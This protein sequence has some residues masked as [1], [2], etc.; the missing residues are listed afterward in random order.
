MELKANVLVLESVSPQESRNDVSDTDS[1]FSSLTAPSSAVLT[2]ISIAF[3]QS[4]MTSVERTDKREAGKALLSK[5]IATGKLTLVKSGA[6][7]TEDLIDDLFCLLVAFL[8]TEDVILV[9]K[10]SD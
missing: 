6:L 1:M 5:Y 3:K 8:A 4:P 2:A 7:S 10:L 9:K